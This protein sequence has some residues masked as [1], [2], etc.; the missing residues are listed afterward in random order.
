MVSLLTFL[1]THNNPL[2]PPSTSAKKSGSPALD[3]NLSSP[4]IYH[5]CACRGVSNLFKVAILLTHGCMQNFR[6]LGQSVEED[7]YHIM[8]YSYRNFNI[9][10]NNVLS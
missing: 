6:I 9:G 8:Y 3:D 10:G 5:I 4:Q 7:L 1:G 2:S